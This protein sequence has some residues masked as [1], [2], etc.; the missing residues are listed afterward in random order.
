LTCSPPPVITHPAIRTSEGVE[1]A[2]FRKKRD[3]ILYE[4]QAKV[5]DLKRK[6]T[7]EALNSPSN[8]KT[9]LNSP[10]EVSSES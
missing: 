4:P 9:L 2:V 5:M 1:P 6:A 8:K 7:I 3:P 10:N